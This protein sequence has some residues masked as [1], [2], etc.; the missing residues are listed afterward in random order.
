M[1][2][3]LLLALCILA[4][5]LTSVPVWSDNSPIGSWIGVVSDGNRRI[6]VTLTVGALTVGAKNG[7]MRW[8]T[9]RTCSL[10]TEYAGMK[11]TQYTLNIS[12]TN[13]GWCDLYRDGTLMIQ[14]SADALT[15]KLADKDGAKPVDGQLLPKP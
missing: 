7:E 4:I 5:P 15:F 12:G 6:A 10:S 3:R 14:P 13:G 8:G 11:D 2:K 9:P 1:S